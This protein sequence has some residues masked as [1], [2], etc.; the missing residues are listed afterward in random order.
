MIDRQA[1]ILLRILVGEEKLAA[2]NDHF[3]LASNDAEL[4]GRVANAEIT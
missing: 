1:Q 4:T 3:L 2:G